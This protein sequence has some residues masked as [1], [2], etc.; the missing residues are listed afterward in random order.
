MRY[1]SRILIA[2]VAGTTLLLLSHMGFSQSCPASH[3]FQCGG[4]CYVDAAQAQAGGC[5]ESS[6][7]SSSGQSSSNSSDNSNNAGNNLTCASD[8]NPSH[9]VSGRRQQFTQP[10]CD[11]VCVTYVGNGTGCLNAAGTFVSNASIC[12]DPANARE[13]IID[14][15]YNLGI[16]IDD[17]FQA[18]SGYQ[19]APPSINPTMT[20][21]DAETYFSA[22]IGEQKGV[23]LVSLLNTNGDNIVTR[24][25]ASQAKGS[26]PRQ[27]LNTGFGCGL[28]TDDIMAYVG[29]YVGDGAI[30]KY[31]G[32]LD[33][34]VKAAML[35]F[36]RSWQPGVDAQ[37]CEYRGGCNGNNPVSSS[38][39][40]VSSSSSSSVSSASSSSPGN[41][42]C[43]ASH[44]L[45]SQSCAQCFTD[46]A[47]AASAGCSQ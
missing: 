27:L 32:D 46:A 23:E 15:E 25:E 41:P 12:S 30:D 28:S 10:W 39:S 14:I 40:S 7:S 42:N 2:P 37:A 44:P 43:P 18:M 31:A 20:V 17:Q 38:S 11:T 19:G 35:E 47:Q 34:S 29:L 3:P 21:A 33:D 22:L 13:A 45:W 36:T 5:S 9:V 16:E 8:E 6:T 4:A 24:N 26:D 1:L